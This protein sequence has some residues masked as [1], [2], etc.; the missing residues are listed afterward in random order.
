MTFTPSPWR[1]LLISLSTV[2]AILPL[3]AHHCSL[4][5]FGRQYTFERTSTSRTLLLPVDKTAKQPFIEEFPHF[6]PIQ[7][8]WQKPYHS[9]YLFNVGLHFQLQLRCHFHY[10]TKPSYWCL[11]LTSRSRVINKSSRDFVTPLICTIIEDK[12]QNHCSFR[13]LLDTNVT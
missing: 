10:S 7:G 1:V 3:L 11:L 9:C 6:L 5:L 8:T 2:T 4:H 12:M 13:L